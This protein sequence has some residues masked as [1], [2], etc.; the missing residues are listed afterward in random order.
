[1]P[2]HRKKARI[3]VVTT[4]VINIAANT[5]TSI[6]T[7]VES[8]TVELEI[9]VVEMWLGTK[10]DTPFSA[11]TV[12]LYCTSGLRPI[13]KTPHHIMPTCSEPILQL[14]RNA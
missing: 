8:E 2:T 3:V 9:A 6:T 14:L 10:D 13:G 7:I 4:K 12:M 11:V 1:L 5:A